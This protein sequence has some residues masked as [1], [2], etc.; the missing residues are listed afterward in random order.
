EEE[1]QRKRANLDKKFKKYQRAKERGDTAK[2]KKLEYE[3]WQDMLSLAASHSDPAVR[4]EW[5]KKAEDFIRAAETGDE[6]MVMDIAK[7]LGLVVAAPFI[8]AGTALY[9]VGLLTKG[10]GNL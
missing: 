7:G 5:K 2:A 4:A 8:L 3:L 10:L 9:G 6:S 1:W